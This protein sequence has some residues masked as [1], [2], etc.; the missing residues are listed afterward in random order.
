MEEEDERCSQAGL[1]RCRFGRAR[2]RACARSHT[3]SHPQRGEEVTNLVINSA[4]LTDHANQGS[5]EQGSRESTAHHHSRARAFHAQ[6]S[7][8]LMSLARDLMRA[9]AR[10]AI[11]TSC[12]MYSSYRATGAV[13]TSPSPPPLPTP[14]A[15]L[16]LLLRLLRCVDK[17]HG[18][19]IQ[20]LPQ[21]VC[22][23]GSTRPALRRRRRLLFQPRVGF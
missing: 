5:R 12:C 11:A 17:H 19:L 20:H 22:A 2:A 7:C 1:V 14:A 3:R 23:T 6:T 18:G 10:I 4:V 15:H 9:L 21:T 8:V 16:R 13:Q